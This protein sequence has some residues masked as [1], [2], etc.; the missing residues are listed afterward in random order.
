MF[1]GRRSKTVQLPPSTEPQRPTPQPT[2]HDVVKRYQHP[3]LKRSLWQVINTFVPFFALWYL[4]YRSLAYSYLLT[5]L[6][7]IVIGGLTT[8]IFIIFHDCGHG[9]FFKSQ[10]WNDALGIFCSLF[11]MTP[12]Y[13]WRHD[14]AVHHATAGDLDRR[15]IGDITTLTV[16]EYLARSRWGRLAYRLYRH[17]LILFGVGPLYL[18]LISQRFVSSSAKRRERRSVYWTNGALALLA[19]GLALWLGPVPFLLIQVPITVVASAAGVW[20]FYVQHQFE[21]TYWEYHDTWQY[22][23]AALRG[24]SHYQLPMVLRWFSGNIG[25][26]H[27]HHLNARIPNYRL[28]QCHRENPQFQQV[29]TLTLRS[30]LACIG[31]T[32]W[33]EEQRRLVG[34]GSLKAQRTG[35]HPHTVR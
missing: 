16:S 31:L 24:S 33:D 5:L 30:S 10:S 12:Y 15:G 35:Q 4:A 7:A 21:D 27:I 34:F 26:H 32:L 22:R 20:L 18:F 13:Q 11:V 25:L 2:W 1:T 3:D 23:L 9:S 14:H 28:Q 8:R 6:I 19:I 17:P 29:T